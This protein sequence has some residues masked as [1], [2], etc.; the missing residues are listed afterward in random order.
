MSYKIQY[1]AEA[2]MDLRD[3]YNYIALELLVPDTAKGQTRRIMDAIK[4]LD[5]FPMRYSLYKDEP[6]NSKGL[7]FLPIDNYMV[8][9]LPNEEME[10]VNIVRIMYIGRD[11]SKQLD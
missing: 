2:R 3:I 9:Y 11:I 5:T 7:R 1:S 10:T 6:W 8:L 4:T